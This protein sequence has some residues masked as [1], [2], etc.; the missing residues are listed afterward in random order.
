MW[1][2]S[3]TDAL[4]VSSRALTAQSSANSRQERIKRT[5]SPCAVPDLVDQGPELGEGGGEAGGVGLLESDV[6]LVPCRTEGDGCGVSKG[7]GLELCGE[8]VVD[9]RT[10]LDTVQRQPAPANA[11]I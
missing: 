9:S 7:E 4:H 11:I 8:T 3:A 2:E 6:Q 1:E 10:K 5:C